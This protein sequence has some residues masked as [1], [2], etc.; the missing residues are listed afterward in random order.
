[1]CKVLK[2]G[3]SGL[4]ILYAETLKGMGIPMSRPNKSSMQFHGVNP[5]KKAKSLGQIALDVVFGDEENFRKEM[6]TFEMVDFHIAYHA[7]LRWSAYACFMARPCYVYLK[8]KMLG[9]K[10][11]ITVTGNR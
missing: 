5:R 7:I 6:L 11:V 10:G 8:L 3:G 4:K 9:P 1:M 2:D